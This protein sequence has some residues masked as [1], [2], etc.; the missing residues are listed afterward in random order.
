MAFLFGAFGG[1][2]LRNMI[3]TNALFGYYEL[4]KMDGGW[5]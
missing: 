1:V 4:V 2:F 5:I 3:S